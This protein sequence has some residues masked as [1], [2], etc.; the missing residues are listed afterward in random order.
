MIGMIFALRRSTSRSEIEYQKNVMLLHDKIT[1]NAF[2]YLDSTWLIHKKKFICAWTNKVNI[3]DTLWLHE[4]KE[5][6]Q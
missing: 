3:L 6:T 5:D 2:H 1:V 4:L